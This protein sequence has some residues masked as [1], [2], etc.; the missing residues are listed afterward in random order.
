M[1]ENVTLD[2]LHKARA[3]WGRT[4]K[5]ISAKN[6]KI[7]A[8]SSKKLFDETF[9]HLKCVKIPTTTDFAAKCNTASTQRRL[10]FGRKLYEGRTVSIDS[11]ELLTVI[12]GWLCDSVVEWVLATIVAASG[13]RNIYLVEPYAAAALFSLNARNHELMMTEYHKIMAHK[14]RK[15]LVPF[16]DGQHYVLLFIDIQRKKFICV[17]SNRSYSST[18]AAEFFSRI[19]IVG[20]TAKDAIWEQKEEWI[21][22][23]PECSQQD[24][25]ESCGIFLTEFAKQILNESENF[26]V[27]VD[28][29]AWRR[30]MYKKLYLQCYL[31]HPSCTMCGRFDSVCITWKCT[32]CPY[33]VCESCAGENK[34]IFCG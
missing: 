23:D 21:L 19:K 28:A 29:V 2:E 16:C 4:P 6:K 34:C 17:D 9:K 8:R 7:A 24:D 31:D 30:Q 10:Y 27:K 15:L 33:L 25:G 3:Q 22:K 12:S 14:D 11:P 13:K 20:D 18:K 26:M 32:K 1:D 5:R